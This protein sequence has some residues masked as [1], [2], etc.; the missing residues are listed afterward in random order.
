MHII[1]LT[2]HFGKIVCYFL[3]FLLNSLDKLAKK[4]T[5]GR[6]FRHFQQHID[7]VTPETVLLFRNRFRYFFTLPP[8]SS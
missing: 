2:P 3:L 7:A 1:Y 5:L 8:G 6:I 4:Y